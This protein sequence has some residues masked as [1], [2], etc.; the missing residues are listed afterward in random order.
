MTA[1]RPYVELGAASEITKRLTMFMLT[2]AFAGQ[3]K[4]P[5]VHEIL[6][7]FQRL[8]ALGELYRRSDRAFNAMQGV[9]YG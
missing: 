6:E 5:A 9:R 4:G 3:S 8:N 1:L 7:P 2:V